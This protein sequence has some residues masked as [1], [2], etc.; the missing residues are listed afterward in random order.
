MKSGNLEPMMLETIPRENLPYTNFLNKLE[1]HTQW[2]RSKWLS[3][4]YGKPKKIV[5]CLS[6]SAIR[7]TTKWIRNFRLF[8]IITF[9]K[10][11]LVISE[12][13]SSHSDGIMI[14][15]LITTI[16]ED[17]A[18]LGLLILK[19]EKQFSLLFFI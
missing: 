18:C 12:R 7:L 13:R 10:Q 8:R 2:L 5:F 16:W 15:L 14:I 6:A 3:I 17:I 4:I 1:S 11:K 19:M 9:V